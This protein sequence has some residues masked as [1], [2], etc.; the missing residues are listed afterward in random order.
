MPSSISTTSERC[1]L[2]AEA[3]VNHNGDPELALALIDAAASAG[4]DAVKFQTFRSEALSSRHAAKARYQVETTGADDG[5]LA[6]LRRL[7]L[8]APTHL[9]LQKHAALRGID[10]L[11]TPF[12]LASAELLLTELAL[13]RLK[14]GSGDLDNG[15]LLW[16]VATAGVPLI[17]ST[18]MATLGE[19]EAALGVIACAYLGAQPGRAAFARAYA[20]PAAQ[21]L[22]RER[23][24][25]LH[26]TTEYPAPFDQLELRAMA[27]LTAAFGLPVGYSDHSE[28][29]AVAP[30][31]VALGAVVLEKHLTLDRTL[32]GPD[33]RASLEPAQFAA[34]VQ[35]VRE[36]EAA[37][38]A[39]RKCPGPAEWPNRAVARKSLVAA[40]AITAGEL[41]TPANLTTKRPGHGRSPL[42]YWD[43][44]GSGAARDYGEDEV[45]DP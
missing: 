31:A 29:T 43:V 18:G 25:L 13:P 16:R 9:R 20:D 37:L 27:T 2:I 22:L 17:L 35:A 4:A 5:Q 3:G 11:S 7:E 8:D 38:G 32:P 15:P 10:F 1:Y 30:A 12:D 21:P 26:C 40:Q 19:I 14:I 39:G 28:G 6:M 42:D 36:V 45:I 33:H 24:T 41:F 34:M 23:V 44:L